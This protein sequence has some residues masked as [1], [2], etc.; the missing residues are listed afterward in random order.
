MISDNTTVAGKLSD[1]FS[2]IGT[3]ATYLAWRA[4]VPPP[5]APPA[6]AAPVADTMTSFTPADMY[7]GTAAAFN[8]WKTQSITYVPEVAPPE[9]P[10]DNT[11]LYLAAFL[12]VISLVVLVKR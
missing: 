4:S 7:A 3:P 1:F 6:P 2:N 11:Y 8:D 12:G 10:K 9:P 5:T